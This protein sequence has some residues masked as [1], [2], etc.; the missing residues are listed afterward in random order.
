M[1]PSPPFHA[2]ADGIFDMGLNEENIIQKR[3]K[4]ATHTHTHSAQKMVYISFVSLKK[5]LLLGVLNR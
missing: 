4:K 5:A 2:K 3:L 1:P